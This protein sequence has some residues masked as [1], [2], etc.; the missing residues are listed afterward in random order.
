MEIHSNLWAIELS[1]IKTDKILHNSGSK[2]I[3]M[4]NKQI[5]KFSSDRRAKKI[6]E[7]YLHQHQDAR[8]I[9]QIISR[10]KEKLIKNS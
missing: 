5:H 7:I 2:P 4:F 6:R 3:F 9:K 8:D 1:Q 10:M